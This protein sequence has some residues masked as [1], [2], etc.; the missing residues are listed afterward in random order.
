M[1]HLFR[2]QD[3]DGKLHPKW[4]FQYTDWR[5][6]RH[7]KTGT[8]S[9]KETE[10]LA[11]RIDAYHEEIRR[12]FRPA[13]KLADEAAQRPFATLVNEYLAW[14]N[15]QGG[16]RGR[17]WSKGHSRMQRARLKWWE[18]QLHPKSLS[19]LEKCLPHVEK[20]LRGQQ[21]RG[22]SGKTINDYAA[23][24][25]SFCNWCIDRDYMENDPLKK[26]K[27]F[28]STPKEVRRAMTAEEIMRL[29]EVAPEY[30]RILYETA[31]CS[32]LR[33]KEL[34]SLTIHDLDLRRSGLC[35]HAEWT[36]NRVGG[37]Q[38]LP[39]VVLHHLA[40]F[41]ATGQAKAVYRRQFIRAGSKADHLGEPL[42]Y[43]PTHPSRTLR[44]DLQAAGI[45]IR[46]EEGKIDFHALRVAFVSFVVETGT[47]LKTAQSLARHTNPELTMNVYAR[48]RGT[49][50]SEV[51]EAVGRIILP[52]KSTVVAQRNLRDAVSHLLPMPYA[53]PTSASIPAAS[54]S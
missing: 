24:L 33:A 4:R 46:T 54:T 37:F 1:A 51:A 23:T 9:R 28:D 27:R 16:R 8:S 14:G 2:T 5:G 40:E 34:K 20:A 19:S 29:L 31:F 17:A 22:T 12:G 30:R 6:K 44:T 25:H 39:S 15:S 10:K 42:L 52:L 49:R 11:Q 36:K 47:D 43:V 7:T 50:L 45:P 21:E 3:K 41:A 32:G 35:L 13:P 18:E 26:L 48:V 53:Q 38:P